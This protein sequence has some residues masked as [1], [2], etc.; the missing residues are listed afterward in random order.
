MCLLLLWSCDVESIK[1]VL[2]GKGV[3]IFGF[4]KAIT[5]DNCR[6]GNPQLFSQNLIHN[7]IF[8]F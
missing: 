6:G 2:R 3:G 1:D 4:F 7:T 8:R 5:M